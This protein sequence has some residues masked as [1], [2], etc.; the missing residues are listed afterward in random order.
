MIKRLARPAHAAIL[1]EQARRLE[2]EAAALLRLADE[3]ER[4]T[5][6]DPALPELD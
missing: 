1:R 2:Q 3:I 4:E 6:E 5:G